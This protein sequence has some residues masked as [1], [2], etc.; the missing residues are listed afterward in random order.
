[1]C[2]A[3]S[4]A[5]PFDHLGSAIQLSVF[6]IFAPDAG[7]GGLN[8]LLEAGGQLAVG[9]DEGLLGFHLG[10]DGVLFRKCRKW[11]L[12]P[13]KVALCDVHKADPAMEVVLDLRDG[14]VQSVE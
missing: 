2:A 10:C 1:M 12:D 5:R 4:N 6:R 11:D 7:E 13:L 3:R 14:A 9:C 8:F